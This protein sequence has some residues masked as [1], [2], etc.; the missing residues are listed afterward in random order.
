MKRLNAIVALMVAGIFLAGCEVTIIPGP[1]NLNPKEVKPVILQPVAGQTPLDLLTLKEKKVQTIFYPDW[2]YY[3]IQIGKVKNEIELGSEGRYWV[4]YVNGNQVKE[5]VD[6]VQLKGD[7]KIEFRF[8][9][10]G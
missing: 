8:E 7:E 5:G 4:L 2:G 1:S 10:A 3:V 9:K 6:R